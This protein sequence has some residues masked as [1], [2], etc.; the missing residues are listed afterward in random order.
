MFAVTPVV[1]W[2]FSRVSCRGTF[3]NARERVPVARALRPPPPLFER[4]GPVAIAE[5]AEQ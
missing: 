4:V 1:N 3:G 2:Q 5:A